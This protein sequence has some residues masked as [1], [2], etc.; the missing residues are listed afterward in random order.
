M[1]HQPVSAFADMARAI[2]LARLKDAR[3]QPCFHGLFD[4]ESRKQP[5]LF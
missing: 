1:P 2:D 5:E 4:T 3:R